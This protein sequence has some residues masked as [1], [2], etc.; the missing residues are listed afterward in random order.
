MNDYSYILLLY[1]YVYIVNVHENGDKCA[2]DKMLACC[3][4]IMVLS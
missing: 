3:E 4:I 1:V 2:S